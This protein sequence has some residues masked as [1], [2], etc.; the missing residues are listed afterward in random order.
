MATNSANPEKKWNVK[1]LQFIVFGIAFLLLA[2]WNINTFT[3]GLFSA[4]PDSPDC[5]R[6][7]GIVTEVYASGG[8]SKRPKENYHLRYVYEVDGEEYESREQVDY[9]IYTNTRL[10]TKIEVCYMKDKPGRSAIIGNDVKGSNA[11]YV[12]LADLFVIGLIAYVIYAGI[13]RRRKAAQA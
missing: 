4:H 6:T 1:R 13:K 7:N 5:I 2:Y 12:I 8:S 10:G 9:T 11:F 3:G